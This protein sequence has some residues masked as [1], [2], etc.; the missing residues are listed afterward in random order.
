MS[1]A[2]DIVVLDVFRTGA[3]FQ[4]LFAFDDNVFVGPLERIPAASVRLWL[5]NREQV[6]G[7]LG[8]VVEEGPVVPDPRVVEM[9]L[10]GQ[11]R[12]DRLGEPVTVAVILAA[13]AAAAI[14]RYGPG[15]VE[16]VVEGVE[17][18][19]GINTCAADNKRKHRE[20]IEALINSG[21]EGL[22]AIADG[23]AEGQMTGATGECLKYSLRWASKRVME[24]SKEAGLPVQDVKALESAARVVPLDE[25]RRQ[26]EAIAG[27]SHADQETC[28]TAVADYLRGARPV[29]W[30]AVNR[31][32]APRCGRLPNSGGGCD[33]PPDVLLLG[34]G[35]DG[36]C[37]ATLAQQREMVAV[38]E[39]LTAS[40]RDQL[41]VLPI[42][43]RATAVREM[44]LAGGSAAAPIE[45]E[46]SGLAWGL[47]ALATLG[48][49]WWLI[50][51]SKGRR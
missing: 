49:G 34:T 16:W 36:F 24:L 38:V 37:A 2:D 32:V 1:I 18:F 21:P 4:V 22:R 20:R 17:S 28:R 30:R 47:A 10:R 11:R 43:M 50:K 23:L 15:V 45:S 3:D 8:D 39:R 48:G 46:G 51:R 33:F 44:L 19:L 25:A 27:R 13:A 35:Q 26:A 40:Q 31:E 29:D 9:L 7:A 12:D 6:L 42:G 41:A 14:A 5:D